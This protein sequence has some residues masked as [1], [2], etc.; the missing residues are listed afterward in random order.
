MNKKVVVPFFLIAMLLLAACNSASLANA[1][2]QPNSEITQQAATAT[3]N[4]PVTLETANPTVTP[5][6]TATLS[7]VAAAT[8]TQTPTATPTA[9][10]TLVPT[11][12]PTHTPTLAPASGPCNLASFVGDVTIPDG[13]VFN[14]GD[15]FTKT[16]RLHNLG[17]C[18]WTT[19]YALVF[20]GG[21]AMSGPTAVPL[22]ANVTPGG[23]ID[24]SVNLVAPS[25]S[26]TYQGNWVLSDPDGNLFGVGLNGNQAFWVNIVVQ[27][28]A[29]FTVTEVDESMNS[30][31]S[32]GEC[33]ATFTFNANIWTNGAGSVTYHWQ[34]SDGSQSPSGTLT[35][36]GTGYQTVSDIWSLGTSDTVISGW[37]EVVIDQPTLQS[38]SPV[39]FSLTCDQATPTQTPTTTPTQTSTPTQTP[40]LTPTPTPTQTLTPT[41]TQTPTTAPT[42]TPTLTQTPAPTQTPTPT[43]TSTPTQP[44]PAQTSTP[45]QTQTPTPTQTPTLTPT[46][47]H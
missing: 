35:Y 33:Q 9:T 1:N 12:T 8:Q 31:L 36:T 23:T 2:A 45:T 19:S 15:S 42:H 26:G 16:W 25:S 27:S 39:N 47:K 38:F 30:V 5:T 32:S 7:E 29:G 6:P 10:S 3:A 11:L 18:T 17:A 13:T 4:L 37:D 46:A 43:Q 28:Y 44:A 20:A 14:P 24:L 40:T 22:P 41:L 34:R 21:D